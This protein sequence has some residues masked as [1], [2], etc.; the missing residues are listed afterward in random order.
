MAKV[1]KSFKISLAANECIKVLQES[2]EKNGNDF[3]QTEIV[4]QAIFHYLVAI[5]G[6][7]EL[8]RII[9]ESVK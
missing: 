7:K 6:E 1:S 9:L 8:S 2:A 3:N 5:K 4:E